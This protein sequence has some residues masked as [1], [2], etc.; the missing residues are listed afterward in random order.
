MVDTISGVDYQR[1][2]AFGPDAGNIAQSEAFVSALSSAATVIMVV[3]F[4]G[5]AVAL[6]LPKMLSSPK[7]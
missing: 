1:I 6:F 5:V 3:L 4:L 7:T 2:Q